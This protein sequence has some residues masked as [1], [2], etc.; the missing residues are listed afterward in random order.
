[1]KA[2][3]SIDYTHDFVATDGKLTT[4]DSGQAIE[5]ALTKVTQS[6][7]DSGDYV[8]FA[9]DAHDP[10]DTYHPENHLFPA[11][12]V[13]GTSG[14][15][16]FG[17]LSAIYETNKENPQ[18][19]WIDKRHYSAFSGTDLD[20]R[21]RERGIKELH[22]TGVCTDICVLHTAVDAYNLGYK[23]V[24]Y[25]EAVASFDPMGHK[26]ALKHFKNTLGAEIK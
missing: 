9:I 23:L 3:L 16:L 12:N 14:R 22:L 21:L 19:Y 8:V 18:I 13:I 2:L 25:K 4:G 7:I 11:H 5:E 20:I 15:D 1:M 26:W 6:F 10:M 17:S 24:I